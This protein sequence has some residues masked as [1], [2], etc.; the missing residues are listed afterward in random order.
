MNYAKIIHWK[1][2]YEIVAVDILDQQAPI[3]LPNKCGLS[4]KIVREFKHIDLASLVHSF[5]FNCKGILAA[6]LM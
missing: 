2:L 3:R 1:A 4:Q 5:S 6:L